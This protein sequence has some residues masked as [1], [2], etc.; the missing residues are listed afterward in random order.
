MG[1]HVRFSSLVRAAVLSV[2]LVAASSCSTG[3]P[4]GNPGPTA[5][6]ASPAASTAT[7]SPGS[8]AAANCDAGAWRS[9][10]VSVSHPVTGPTVPVVTAARAAAHP[11]C[12]YDRLVLD[13]TGPV[14]SYEIRY[15]TQVIADPSGKP[16]TLSGHRYLLMTLHPAQAHAD[17]GAATIIR[18]EQ[19]LG[20]PVLK[21]YAVAGDFEGVFTVALGL[22]DTTSIRVGELPGHLYIDVRA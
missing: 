20:Y 6:P 1:F 17:S 7:A 18:P 9:A 10:P 2:A 15:V 14:P 11:E 13:V 3:E 21:S 4:A 5:K 22:G 12:G 8:S 16:I 19:T